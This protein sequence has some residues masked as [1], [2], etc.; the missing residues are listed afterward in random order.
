[1]R[2]ELAQAGDAVPVAARTQRPRASPAPGRRARAAVL[3]QAARCVARH[4]NATR[5]RNIGQGWG[6]RG[7]AECVPPGG[8]GVGAAIQVE[9]CERCCTAMQKWRIVTVEISGGRSLTK[10]FRDAR[11]FPSYTRVARTHMYTYAA[12]VWDWSL[13]Q[14]PFS[15]AP[16]QTLALRFATCSSRHGAVSSQGWRCRCCSRRRWTSWPRGCD[17]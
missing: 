13:V 8:G 17:T 11:R 5:T 1:L 2:K 10:P 6:L 7:G 16:C 12:Q 3:R 14:G 15:V 9:L 4:N